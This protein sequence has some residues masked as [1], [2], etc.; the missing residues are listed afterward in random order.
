MGS[1]GTPSPD[2]VPR[3]FCHGRATL[4]RRALIKVLFPHSCLGGL[5][6]D[7]WGN[8]AAN[9]S[10]PGKHSCSHS[11]CP[12]QESTMRLSRAGR[13]LS[14]PQL[15]VYREPKTWARLSALES[16]S[17]P[18]SKI[19][20]PLGFPIRRPSGHGRHFPWMTLQVTFLSG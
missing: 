9:S 20:I 4:F 10:I 12:F 5:Y 16:S 15:P 6:P 7:S 19:Q 14:A 8:N 2:W 1:Q 18:V 17:K 3:R 13:G 11:A